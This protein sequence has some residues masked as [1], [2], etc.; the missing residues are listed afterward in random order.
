MEFSRQEWVAWSGVGSH[1]LLQGIFP[2]QASNPCLLWLLRW[3]AD[4]SPLSHLGFDT[5]VRAAYVTVACLLQAETNTGLLRRILLPQDLN[6][7]CKYT[8]LSN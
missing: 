4:S 1:S 2:T 6:D 7:F 3:W 8:Y 5:L